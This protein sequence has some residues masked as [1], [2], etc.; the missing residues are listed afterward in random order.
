MTRPARWPR[1][2]TVGHSD[3]SLE[4]FLALLAASSVRLVA[5]VRANPTSERFPWFERAALARSLEERG[6]AYRW[7]RD[8]GGRRPPTRGEDEHTALASEGLRRY[9]AA[10]SLP[11]FEAAVRDLLGL[12]SSAVVAVMCAERDWR[13]CHRALLADKLHVMGAEVVHILGPDEVEPHDVHPDLHEENGRIVY[14]TRQL[15]LI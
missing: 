14:R 5:D 13:E 10:M 7:F 12:A 1:I 9:A 2:F 11:E 8:L 15:K 6:L 3:R 4:S